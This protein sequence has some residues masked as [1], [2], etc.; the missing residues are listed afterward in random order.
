VPPGGLRLAETLRPFAFDGPHLIVDDVLTTGRSMERH[1]DE[2]KK[3]RADPGPRY[4]GAVIFAS[5]QCPFWVDALFGMP[6]KFWPQPAEALGLH[7]VHRT[8][9][10]RL[11]GA[12][13]QIGHAGLLLR[14]IRGHH[15]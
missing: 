15:R 14:L 10:L 7:G 11:I 3:A 5:G 9:V 4:V 13:H 2:L 6:E 8:V 12:H 1:L